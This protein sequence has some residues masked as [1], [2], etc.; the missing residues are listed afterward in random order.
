MCIF[1][2]N[3]SGKKNLKK[4]GN[5]GRRQEVQAAGGAQRAGVVHQPVRESDC[6]EEAGHE[7]DAQDTRLG[8]RR[9][10]R[11]AARAEDRLQGALLVW[12]VCACVFVLCCWFLFVVVVVSQV[13]LC[14]LCLFR[15]C[16]RCF[17]IFDVSHVDVLLVLFVV[18]VCQVLPLC[19]FV[20]LLYRRCFLFFV[21]VAPSLTYHSIEVAG[22]TLSRFL[23][24]CSE[25]AVYSCVN[26]SKGLLNPT[27]LRYHS[28]VGIIPQEGRCGQ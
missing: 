28:Q 3:R 9:G 20:C 15:F 7:L 22:S 8:V 23:R 11:A 6:P 5:F 10:K 13:P 14:V 17:F 25:K 1:F 18:I 19:I 26:R 27:R 4:Q 21:L 24:L 12:C 16:C 2:S